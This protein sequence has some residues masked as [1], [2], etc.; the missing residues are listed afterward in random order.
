MSQAMTVRLRKR[1]S[2]INFR[3][4]YQKMNLT[5]KHKK[6]LGI[7]FFFGLLLCVFVLILYCNSYTGL[8]AD[9]YSYSFSFSSNQRITDAS[10]I[11]DSMLV[12]RHLLNG[13]ILM[14]SF[15]QLFLMLPHGVFDVV[16]SLAFLLELILIIL[17]GG[18]FKKQ[19]WFS[20]S[21]CL[22]VAFSSFLLFQPSFGEVNLWLDGSINYLWSSVLFL[23]YLLGYLRLCYKGRISDHKIVNILFILFSFAVGSSHE[24]VGITSIGLFVFVLARL[25]IKKTRLNA[26]M[27]LSFLSNLAGFIL[28]LSAPIEN[29]GKL[30]TGSFIENVDFIFWRAMGWMYVARRILPLVVIFI[31][32][33]LISSFMHAKKEVLEV[34]AMLLVLS[35]L[36]FFPFVF[37]T[38]LVGRCAFLTTSI[39]IAGCV[40]LIGEIAD[41]K[42]KGVAVVAI[43]TLCLCVGVF[44]VI[45]DGVK[46]IKACFTLSQRIETMILKAK[47]EGISDVAIP[48]ISNK[49]VSEICL[50]NSMCFLDHESHDNWPNVD[51][52]RYYD[53]DYIT[54]SGEDLVI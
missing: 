27:F 47:A 43:L 38:Y 9:D 37:G 29:K 17:C 8:I 3:M 5:E 39:L 34:A 46:D 23:G 24:I 20:L 32:L 7:F 4:D 30:I 35:G 10:Q 13:R 49:G 50:Y 48:D 36:A 42:R 14:H 18:V 28:I 2:T 19:N 40:V 22:F 51:I 52:A 54:Y 16:N 12:H 45:I 53:V 11:F 21:L 44:P 26:W 15:V 25:I 41:Q 1:A 31:I 33:M 6:G